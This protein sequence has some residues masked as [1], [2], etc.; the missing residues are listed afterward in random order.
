MELTFAPNGHLQI[1]DAT[2]VYKNFEGRGDKFNREGDKNFHVRIFDE[3]MADALVND[4]NDYGIGW[5]VKVKPPREDG[6]DPFMSLKVKVKFNNR[7][8]KVV[9]ISGDSRVE[10]DEGSIKCLDNIEIERV[11]LDIRPYDD[12]VNGAPFR[13]AYLDKLYVTQRYNRFIDRYGF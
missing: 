9:L 5:N 13:T 4:K 1:D 7:G 3:A 11:D 2:L 12:I 8:P 10:L 6:D